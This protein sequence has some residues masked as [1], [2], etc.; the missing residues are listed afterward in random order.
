MSSPNGWDGTLGRAVEQS[1]FG[2]VLLD[3][4]GRIAR[5][6]A[7]VCELLGYTDETLRGRSLVELV[8]CDDRGWAE[9]ELESLFA[10][11]LER[12]RGEVR[13]IAANDQVVPAELNVHLVDMDE[14]TWAVAML[15]DARDR[16]ARER[17]LRRLA[18]TDPLTDLFNRRRFTAEL[19][20]HLEQSRRYGPTGALLVID[21][22]SLKRINDD[23]GHLAGD[24][25]IVGLANI[26]RNKLRASDVVARI[27]GDEFAVLLPTASTQQAKT[28]A[29]SIL[30]VGRAHPRNQGCVTASIGIAAVGPLT[31][32]PT[33]LLDRADSAMYAVKRSGGDGCAVDDQRLSVIS[34][35]S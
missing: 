12:V 25:A 7:P 1:R 14:A 22:D 17:E 2:F 8:H 9:P 23:R 19:E 30:A 11:E 13:L 15:E 6:N 21:I 24:R 16:V 33:A 35:G 32:Q 10:G 20:R 18:E 29:E 28:V 34:S 4:R 26:L 3:R 31:L 5:A 27:G